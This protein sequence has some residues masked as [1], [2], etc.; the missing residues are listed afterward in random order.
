MN[1]SQQVSFGRILNLE[2]DARTSFQLHQAW[3]WYLKA[4]SLILSSLSQH[5]LCVHAPL[6]PCMGMHAC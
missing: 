3:Y 6:L 4:P 1:W 2:E 5:H